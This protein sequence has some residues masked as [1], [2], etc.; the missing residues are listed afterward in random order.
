MLFCAAHASGGEKEVFVLRE[1][2]VRLLRAAAVLWAPIES[3]APMVAYS[4]RLVESDGIPYENVARTA[5]LPLGSPPSEAEK[6]AIDVLVAELPRAFVAFMERATLAPGRYEYR[7]PLVGIEH[8]DGLLAPSLSAHARETTVAFELK[9]EHA[10]LLRR[11]SW[12]GLE[13]GSMAGY[14]GL[15]PKRPYGDMTYF[16]LD[17]AEILGEPTP[18]D[19]D[20][21][22]APAQEARLGRLHEEMQAALQIFLQ[23]AQLPAPPAP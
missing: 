1:Q 19:R 16:E 18:R 12:E 11:G 5:G 15:D 2:H 7:N 6:R 17:M 13:K 9:P 10:K 14:M 4:P 3:G 23:H 20:G 22:L 21:R 8:A